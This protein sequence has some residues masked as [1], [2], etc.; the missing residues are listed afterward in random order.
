MFLAWFGFYL[1]MFNK[2]RFSFGGFFVILF[3]YVFTYIWFFFL[4]EGFG[5]CYILTCDSFIYLFIFSLIYF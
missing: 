1:F 4:V 2:Y 3:M 5:F